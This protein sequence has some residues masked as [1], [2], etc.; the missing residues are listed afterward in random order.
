LSPLGYVLV[1]LASSTVLP[2][3][4][5]A[6]AGEWPQVRLFAALGLGTALVGGVAIRLVP[7]R[8]LAPP[9]ALALT[10]L[11]YL[12]F[13]LLG[14][15]PFLGQASWLDG[16]FE[17]TSGITTTGLSVLSPQELP[18][19][20]LFFRSLYQWLGG[21]GIVVIPGPAAPPGAHRPEPLHR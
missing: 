1:V 15:I 5:A 3:L 20:L 7:R 6:I 13:S 18:R 16:F 11:A 19:S 17:A 12:L 2:L 21:A 14:A 10:A 8:P 9:D 4:V